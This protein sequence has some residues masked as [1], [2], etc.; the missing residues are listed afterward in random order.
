MVED[1]QDSMLSVVTSVFVPLMKPIGLGDWRILVSLISGFMAKESVVTTLNVLYTGGVA[2]SMTTLSAACL[3]IFSLL[4]TPCI[5]AIASIKRELGIKWAFVVVVWQC[6]LA[7]IAALL[8]H[9][10]GLLIG[11]M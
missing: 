2:E 9:L 3:L 11:V 7:W 10:A 1:P 6:A 4:Y 8:V 5:A